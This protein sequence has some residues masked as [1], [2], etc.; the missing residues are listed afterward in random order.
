[1]SKNN[2]LGNYL[3]VVIYLGFCSDVAQG[4]MN[5]APNET[6]THLVC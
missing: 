2:E 5:E 3:Q 4:H 1:M 6:Q